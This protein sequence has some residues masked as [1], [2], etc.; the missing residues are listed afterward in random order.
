ML[1]SHPTAQLHMF[2][3]HLEALFHQFVVQRK[4]KRHGNDKLVDGVHSL[5]EEMEGDNWGQ[6]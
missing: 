1:V 3:S 6:K 4:D 5:K 2:Q